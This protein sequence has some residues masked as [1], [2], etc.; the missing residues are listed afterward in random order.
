M[1]LVFTPTPKSLVN[2]M[3]NGTSNT[4]IFAERYTFCYAN[5]FG[6]GTGTVDDSHPPTGAATTEADDPNGCDSL[7]TQTTHDVMNVAMG[8]GS[9]RSVTSSVSPRTWRIIGN[10]PAYQ[11]QV[12]GPD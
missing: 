10:D 7:I 1:V 5:G 8:D 4:S 12:V 6:S 11:G 9:V 3:L 2:S